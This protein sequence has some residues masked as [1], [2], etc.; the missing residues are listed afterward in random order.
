MVLIAIQTCENVRHYERNLL[1]CTKTLTNY[2]VYGYTVNKLIF[3]TKFHW[4]FIHS[5]AFVCTLE[6]IRYIQAEQLESYDC[7]VCN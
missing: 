3:N 6:H 7:V 5:I 1:S 2:S 4:P